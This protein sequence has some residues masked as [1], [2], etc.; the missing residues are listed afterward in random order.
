MTIVSDADQGFMINDAMFRRNGKAGY[1]LKPQPLREVHKNLLIHRTNHCLEMW[2]ISAQQLPRPRDSQGHEILDKI[3]NKGIADPYVEVLLFV[4][5]WT[6]SPLSPSG[7]D[8]NYARASSAQA[9]GATS[10]KVVSKKTKVVKNNGF[11]PVWDESFSLPFN[12]VGDMKSLVFVKFAIKVEGQDNDEPLAQYVSS[13]EC[14]RQGETLFS[15]LDLVSSMK[16]ISDP[17]MFRLSS[18][19]PPRLATVSI[20]VLD[21]V[22][23]Y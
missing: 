7:S 19:S 14:L 18:Y 10:A 17:S 16:L 20:L 12:C 2:I 1:V 13:L 11:N 15:S 22:Y 3:F 21:V 8:P 4:P 9:G 23:P 5:D 6:Q